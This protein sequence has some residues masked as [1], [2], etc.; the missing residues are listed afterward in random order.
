MGRPAVDEA[1]EKRMG[2]LTRPSAG[3]AIT[4]T[5]GTGAGAVVAAT[6]GT[7]VGAT[8]PASAAVGVA[9][10]TAPAGGV[11]GALVSL[12]CESSKKASTAI[13]TIATTNAMIKPVLDWLFDVVGS[14]FIVYSFCVI[15][16]VM[17]NRFEGL[18]AMGAN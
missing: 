14:S 6:V 15:V 16:M 4:A 7:G 2:V 18:Y 8:V 10:G 12:R 3:A 9:L 13:T 5:G 1:A 17:E 11:A